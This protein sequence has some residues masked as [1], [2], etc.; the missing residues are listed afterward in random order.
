MIAFA[1]A[2]V[3]TT[4]I[5]ALY[6]Y[7]KMTL[8]AQLI[9][10]LES[11]GNVSISNTPPKWISKV[12]YRIRNYMEKSFPL[13]I[14]FNSLENV[15]LFNSS[16]EKKSLSLEDF[17]G[18][19]KRLES[20]EELILNIQ[21]ISEE[22]LQ[23]LDHI[24]NIKHVKRLRVFGD[25]L[26][27]KENTEISLDLEECY[28]AG[29]SISPSVLKCLAQSHNLKKLTL[30]ALTPLNEKHLKYLH[31]LENL[32]E[33]MIQSLKARSESLQF[34]GKF[35]NLRFLSLGPQINVLQQTGNTEN[36][37]LAKYFDL[38]REIGLINSLPKL[39]KLEANIL[40][41]EDNLKEFQNSPNVPVAYYDLPSKIDDD[42]LNL[43]G[44][45][46]KKI[47][48]DSNYLKVGLID[49]M[50]TKN[51]QGITDHSLNFFKLHMPGTLD[52][53]GCNLMSATD[54]QLDKPSKIFFTADTYSK[55]VIPLL[56][57]KEYSILD[58]SHTS[59]DDE[60]L[61]KLL[62]QTVPRVL[63]LEN[64]KVSDKAID[65]LMEVFDEHPK[66]RIKV[67][68]GERPLPENR[69]TVFLQRVHQW[70]MLQVFSSHLD[71]K[72][73]FP[74]WAVHTSKNIVHDQHNTLNELENYFP[75]LNSIK[76]TGKPLTLNDWQGLL[77]LRLLHTVVLDSAQHNSV[78]QKSGI[79]DKINTLQINE[80][81]LEPIMLPNSLES[82]RI[83][84]KKSN[85]LRD[86]INL[87]DSCSQKLIVDGQGSFDL[88]LLTNADNLQE[89]TIGP[90]VTLKDTFPKIPNLAYFKCMASM[91]ESVLHSISKISRLKVLAGD[92]TDLN[93]DILKNLTS[94]KELRA[95]D[96]S[97]TFLSSKDLKPLSKFEQ[98]SVLSLPQNEDI[99]SSILELLSQ[100]PSLSKL[101]INGTSIP[102][103][104][105]IE[106]YETPL[107]W[108]YL[109]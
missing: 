30:K 98:L 106:K 18:I 7:Q 65:M 105:V 5:T 104:S 15:D 88:S 11:A 70:G 29:E 89:L 25:R 81:P 10:E 100:L 3:L 66:E 41:S 34:L 55:K 20:I 95:L 107:I 109:P 77:K 52:F 97:S 23:Y 48:V 2:V 38:S 14:D 76:L 53:R 32:E 99:D 44:K 17:L 13:N 16:T 28:I 84:L 37:S 69:R 57:C 71:K 12:P 51:Q 39:K 56:T 72:I 96:L 19:I 78:M 80:K 8:R 47:S 68:F 49:K 83:I 86:Y 46:L 26:I 62:K 31:H 101:S 91:N 43:F 87:K 102:S 58:F 92:F 75:Q 35:K 82:C 85:N 4:I 93:G 21:G 94:L 60:D 6:I 73:S 63:L 42:Y 54:L 103:Q 50:T 45:F 33:L 61:A 36:Q 40:L 1:L 79:L 9:T 108:D 74:T 24:V 22:K 59:F 64:T 27:L 90:Y 67:S